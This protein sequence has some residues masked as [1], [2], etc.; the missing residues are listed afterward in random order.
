MYHLPHA[1]AFA[2][3]HLDG[4]GKATAA[5]LLERFETL[6]A[7]RRYPREQVLLRLKGLPNATA[8]V[9]RL[10]DDAVMEPAFTAALDTLGSLG[11]KGVTVLAP[12]LP[13]WP[14]SLNRI[15]PADRPALLYVY[16]PTDVVSLRPVALLG[17][18]GLA[19]PAFDAMQALVRKM[20]RFHLSAA[21]GI[22]HGF[23]VVL[24][25][26]ALAE[27][28]PSLMVAS[29][30]LSQVPSSVRAQA[31]QSARGGS[32][33][34]SAWDMEHGPFPHDDRHRG[35]V[36]AALS[37]AVVAFDP[38]PDSVEFHTLV[39]AAKNDIPTY[40]YPGHHPV[41]EGHPAI[42]DLDAFVRTLIG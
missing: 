36:Q 21:G 37:R 32:A 26:I 9:E 35:K 39:W 41:P 14:A 11:R 3:V 13:G 42:E 19:E 23:D 34:L 38:A 28:Q 2:L 12:N 1:F 27:R 7:L 24:H 18:P 16:G 5:R 33:L 15:P 10:R 29:S 4:V 17:A 31:A 8:L 30:G 20:A 6:E 40:V 25:K 22:Q